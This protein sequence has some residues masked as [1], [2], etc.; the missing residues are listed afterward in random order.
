MSSPRLTVEL[1]CRWPPQ[2]HRRLSLNWYPVSEHQDDFGASCSC[3]AAHC[4]QSAKA[5][6]RA[7]PATLD[8]P[9]HTTCPLP[10]PPRA[11]AQ[12]HD[13]PLFLLLVRLVPSLC[14][15]VRS[16]YR[17]N[18]GRISPARVNGQR[19]S[20]VRNVFKH[21]WSCP[22]S[23]AVVYPW[24]LA[25]DRLTAQDAVAAQEA[26]H[27][28]NVDGRRRSTARRPGTGTAAGRAR[29]RCR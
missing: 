1:W 17:R 21:T 22:L 23:A 8:A 11:H 26:Q 9:S 3:G 10:P 5:C 13:R 29:P 25:S 7:W 27:A 20:K 28:W 2:H 16:E 24:A 15:G 18:H 6:D 19:S 4:G 12:L 14:R